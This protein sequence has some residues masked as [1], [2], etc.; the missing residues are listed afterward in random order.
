MRERKKVTDRM[1][2]DGEDICVRCGRTGADA[3]ELLSRARGGS[4]VDRANI[5]ALCRDDHRWVTEN[6]LAAMAEGL[7]KRAE[8]LDTDSRVPAGKSAHGGE[9]G[10]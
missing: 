1:K 7:A 8:V 3:H 4:I 2:A 10:E 5:V 6:P 9:T